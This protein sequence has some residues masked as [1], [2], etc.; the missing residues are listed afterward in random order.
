MGNKKMLQVASGTSVVDT[1]TSTV[2]G[3]LLLKL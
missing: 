3:E 1:K 2:G